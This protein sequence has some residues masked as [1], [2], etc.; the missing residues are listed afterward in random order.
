MSW[1]HRRRNGSRC[2]IPQWPIFRADIQPPVLTLH[3]AE[4]AALSAVLA[5]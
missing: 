5:G 3:D 1:P 2:P 4:V